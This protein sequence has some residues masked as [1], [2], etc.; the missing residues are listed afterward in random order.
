MTFSGAAS[1]GGNITATI[2]NR[3]YQIEAVETPDTYTILAKTFSDT[4]LKFTNVAATSSDS[5]N[6]G[7]SVVA[8]YQ[9]STTASSATEVRGWGA[10]AWGSGPFGTGETSTEE[11]RLWTQQNFGEDLI[12]GPRGGRLYYWDASVDSPL[13]TRAVELS[14]LANA[15]DVPTIQNAILVSDINRFVFC[16]G[17]NTIG[18]STQDPMLIR[19]SDQESAVNWTPAATNQ[20][21][22]LRLSRGT[23]I[24]GAFQGRQEVLVWTDSSLYSLQYV[25]AGSGVWGAQLVGENISIAS[26]NSVV[27]SN[28]VAYWMGKDKFYKYDGRTQPLPCDLRKHV[29]TDFNT[30]QYTQVFGGS[31]EAFHEVWWFYCSSSATDIDKYI[32][33]NYLEDIWYYGS[34]AR[35]AWLDSGLR[36][37]P[38]AATYNGVLVDHENGIDDNE[39][40]TTAAISSF[41]TSAEFD[42]DDGHQFMLMSRVLPDVSF[43][44]STADSPAVAMTFFGLGSSGSGYN[45][46]ASESGVNTG[47]ITRSATSP[48]EVYTTQ[49]HTRVRGRQMS[50]KIESSATGVQWQLGAPRLDMR[51]DGRR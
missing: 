26:Q 25:G 22:S 9:V 31:N 21:G 46:P 48:V 13:E 14:T 34:M 49:V 43:E 4:T 17:G 36:N 24:V 1:L 32:I 38:L 16:F 11:F 27:Y 37:F 33:Y 12:F 10:G 44:G 35:S 8:T 42:L 5:S 15:S 2:L 30:E 3:N 47:T 45:N 29:F 19:W 20:A 40:G 18:T 50:L 28:G 6:G 7:S 23:E 41:I 51:P 39:T